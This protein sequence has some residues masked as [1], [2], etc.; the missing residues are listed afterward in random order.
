LPHTHDVDDDGQT[1]MEPISCEHHFVSRHVPGHLV[2]WVQQC[3]VCHEINW[4]D[5]DREIRSGKRHLS[6]A[7]GRAII[8]LTLDGYKPNQIAEAIDVSEHDVHI[9]LQANKMEL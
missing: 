6:T 2:Y 9:I 7:T 4:D 5:L 1:P 3:S 8:L